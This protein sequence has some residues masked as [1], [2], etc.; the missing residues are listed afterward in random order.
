MLLSF[1][2]WECLLFLYKQDFMG[3]FHK[4]LS[5][6]LNDKKSTFEW[7]LLR[8]RHRIC[9]HFVDMIAVETFNQVL[10]QSWIHPPGS[11]GD[12]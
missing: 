11:V 10:M 12:L 2:I 1:F 4:Q 9:R 3:L 7:M 6:S 5:L 8:L